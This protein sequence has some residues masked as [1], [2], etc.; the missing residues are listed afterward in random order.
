MY[1]QYLFCIL[2]L[3]TQ[4]TFPG[5]S[6]TAFQPKE[7]RAMANRRVTRCS[8]SRPSPQEQRLRCR[9]TGQ[10]Q[11]SAAVASWL[12]KMWTEWARYAA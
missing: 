6:A 7:P 5:A 8:P 3:K 12:R 4:F 10:R 9:G 1:V 11:D 2:N